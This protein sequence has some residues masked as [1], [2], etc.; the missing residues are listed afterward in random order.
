[1]AGLAGEDGVPGAELTGCMLEAELAREGEESP[2]I[3]RR[4]AELVLTPAATM[5][6][7]HYRQM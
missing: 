3:T 2:V 5:R 4:G 7:D 6:L 1:V